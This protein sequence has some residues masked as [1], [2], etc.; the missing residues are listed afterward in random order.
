MA[1]VRKAHLI[2]AL[3]V[4]LPVC[5]QEKASQQILNEN[6]ELNATGTGRGEAAAPEG[7]IRMI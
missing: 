6:Q 3:L 4:A 2:A 1:L 5:A 7:V